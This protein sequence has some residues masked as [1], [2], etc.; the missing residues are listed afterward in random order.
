[1]KLTTVMRDS[2]HKALMD[3]SKDFPKE[4][5]KELMRAAVEGAGLI[6][7]TIMTDW[8]SGTNSGVSTGK[9]ARSFKPTLL[10]SRVGGY[11]V[12]IFS[13]VVYAAIHEDGGTIWPSTARNLAIPLTRAAR[14]VRPRQYPEKL[15]FAITPL[16]NKVLAK[17][18]KKKIKPVYLLVDQVTIRPQHYLKKSAK[19]INRMLEVRYY[20][21]LARF[22]TSTIVKYQ[23]GSG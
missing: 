15:R 8:L 17:Q 23:K 20:N 9:L 13:D 7:E 14:R 6:R 10:E 12:G 2:G 1:M 22:I 4:I 5:R 16:G 3:L 18:L 11:G 19:K 21:T